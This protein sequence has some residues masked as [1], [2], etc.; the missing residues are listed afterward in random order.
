[1]VL[2]RGKNIVL[3]VCGGIAAYKAVEVASRLFK[4]GA[5]VDVIMTQNA[6]RFVTP[7]TFQSISH[8][9]VVTDMFA[10]PKRWEIEHISMSKKADIILVAPATANIIGKASNGIADDMLS[11]TLLATKARILFVPAMNN[12]MYDN[13]ILQGN[14]QKLKSLGHIFM[15]PEIGRMACDLNARTEAANKGRL[16][17]PQSI[18]DEVIKI[19]NTK[20]DMEGFKVLVTAGPTREAIDPVRYI[21]N[22]SSGKMGYAIAEAAYKR[23]ASV[24]LISGPVNIKALDGIQKID[25]NT[26]LEMYDEV[27]KNYKDC[28]I[29]MMVAAVADYRCEKVADSKI[30]KLSDEM[31]L[32]LVKNPD[33]AKEIGKVKEDRILI[34][35]CAETDNVLENAKSKIASKNLDMIMANDVTKVGA[36]FEVD[37]NIVS[38]VKRDGTMI[39]LPLMKKSEVADGLLDEIVKHFI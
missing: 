14:I 3:G 20:R 35:T 34:G 37:T 12:D 2:L 38:I 28:K 39:E 26:A 18:V 11:T 4:L 27:F 1:V 23:G 30:K 24:V 8:N 10:E 33:I 22:R 32:K 21:T 17:E 36:G 15:E 19:L 5:N 13:N 25:V 9:L 16:P 7:L 31:T 6:T 29:L